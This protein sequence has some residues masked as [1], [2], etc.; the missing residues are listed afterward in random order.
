MTTNGSIVQT[1]NLTPNPEA[2]PPAQ[3]KRE[4]P[5]APKRTRRKRKKDTAPSDEMSTEQLAALGTLALEAGK[6]A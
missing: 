2:P 5:A 3:A 6:L 1:D 4:E